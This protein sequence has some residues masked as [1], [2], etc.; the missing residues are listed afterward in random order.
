MDSMETYKYAR[1]DPMNISRILGFP[2]CLTHISCQTHLPK[3]KDEK[4]DDVSHHLIKFHMHTCKLRVELYEDYLMKMFMATLEG[5][6][7]SW[8]K[9]L[10]STS[11]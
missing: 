8:Y 9:R 5:K 7:K 2:N 6:A 3:F 4:G 11:I 1:Y 10:P